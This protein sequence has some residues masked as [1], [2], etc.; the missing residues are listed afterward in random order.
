MV[1][2]VVVSGGEKPTLSSIFRA[3]AEAARLRLGVSLLSEE[4]A[5]VS[6]SADLSERIL[7]C[8][9]DS[10]CVAQQLNVFGVRLAMVVV[11]NLDLEPALLGLQLIDSDGARPLGESIARVPKGEALD[12]ALRDRAAAVFERAGFGKAGRISVRV[13]PGRASVRLLEGVAPE[14][15]AG[16]SFLVPPGRYHV[17]ASFDGYEDGASEV[18]V[19]GGE[20]S[21][22]SLQLIERPKIYESIWFWALIGAVVAGGATAAIVATKRTDRLVC[23]PLAGVDCR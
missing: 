6:S 14:K 23:A 16:A 13:D 1:V 18:T 11:I 5:F 8:G 10:R 15:P 17:Q 22:V 12:E 21:T 20:E 19:A 2:P 3:I 4:E 7:E 9:P